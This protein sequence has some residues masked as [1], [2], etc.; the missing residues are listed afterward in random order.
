MRDRDANRVA[1][2]LAELATKIAAVVPRARKRLR[3]WSSAGYPAG[4]GESSTGSDGHSDPVVRA[5]QATEITNAGGQHIGWR[6]T[7]PFGDR[8]THLDRDLADLRQRAH[9]IYA[10]LAAIDHLYEGPAAE[11]CKLCAD[12]APEHPDAWQ[13]IHN[14]QAP[15]PTGDDDPVTNLPRC[16]WHYDFAKR[17]GVDAHRDI[18][19]WHLDHL[20]ERCPHRLISTYHAEAF[21]RHHSARRTA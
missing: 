4:A 16:S 5:V 21:A 17:Y 7:D 18:T 13:R 9:R 10:E 6:G 8:L 14:R 2:E 15:A 20:G 11:G 19:R 1:G 12:A 3:D